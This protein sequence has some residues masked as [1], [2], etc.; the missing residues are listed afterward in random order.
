MA[1]APQPPRGTPPGHVATLV[2]P[3]HPHPHC[4]GGSDHLPLL[5]DSCPVLALGPAWG[6]HWPESPG[7]VRSRTGHIQSLGRREIRLIWSRNLC[8]CTS[9]GPLPETAKPGVRPLQDRAPTQT[10]LPPE[11]PVSGLGFGFSPA[12]GSGAEIR[13]R[14][15]TGAENRGACQAQAL[16]VMR[17][18]LLGGVPTLSQEK[19]TSRGPP[20]SGV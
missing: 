7:H 14:G 12:S 4:A 18:D 10:D 17:E 19:L 20:S 11:S 15:A 13:H 5:R 16:A 9:L 3:R 8:T 2:G 6:C 1:K